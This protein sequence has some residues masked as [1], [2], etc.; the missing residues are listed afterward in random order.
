MKMT[1]NT[2]HVI[3]GSSGVKSLASLP[4]MIY[5]TPLRYSSCSTPAEQKQLQASHTS[6]FPRSSGQAPHSQSTSSS[7]DCPCGTKLTP[8]TAPGLQHC[9]QTSHTAPAPRMFSPS[10]PVFC[11][12]KGME[13]LSRVLQ[14]LPI[15]SFHHITT[16]LLGHRSETAVPVLC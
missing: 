1:L 14:L 9:R 11:R 4:R 12:I 16:L 15:F 8:R 10:H 2:S 13:K 6:S 5:W 7:W 3:P